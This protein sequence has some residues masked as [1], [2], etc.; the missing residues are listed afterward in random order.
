MRFGQF[1]QGRQGLRK[2]VWSRLCYI[3]RKFIEILVLIESRPSQ[4]PQTPET[5][6]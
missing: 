1:G 4:S 3:D 2:L 6:R 5:L